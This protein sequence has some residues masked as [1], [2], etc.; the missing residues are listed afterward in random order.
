MNG[1]SRHLRLLH[2]EPE[3]LQ[4]RSPLDHHNQLVNSSSFNVLC[5]F[6]FFFMFLL[7]E[8]GQNLNKACNLNN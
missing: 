3:L 1:K 4:R 6:C 8:C 2:S 5:Y 7:A